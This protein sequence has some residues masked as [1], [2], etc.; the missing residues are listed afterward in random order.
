MRSQ[1]LYR[2][3][4]GS[5][6]VKFVLARPIV[7]PIASSLRRIFTIVTCLLSCALQFLR[8]GLYKHL[9]LNRHRLWTVSCIMVGSHTSS[10]AACA[11]ADHVVV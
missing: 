2:A 9:F 7:P 3:V 10:D 5:R 1:V 4:Q 6:G 11:C 8:Q